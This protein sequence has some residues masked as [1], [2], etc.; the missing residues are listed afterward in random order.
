[1]DHSLGSK[2]I[3]RHRMNATFA[4]PGIVV[5]ICGIVLAPSCIG[6][7]PISRPQEAPWTEKP[8][9]EQLASTAI[10]AGEPEDVESSAAKPKVSQLSP[11]VPEGKTQRWAVLVHNARSFQPVLVDHN[12][13]KKERVIIVNNPTSEKVSEAF[14]E[15]PKLSR[16][17]LFFL[18]C[19]HHAAHGYLFNREWPWVCV[20][21]QL[22]RIGATNV[23][24]LEIC[25]GGLAI[26]RL[27]SAEMVYSACDSF[28][29]C[30][31]IF[32]T[33]FIAA[34]VSPASDAD[35][36]GHISMGEAYDKA[37][38]R[39]PLRKEYAKLNKRSPRFWPVPRGPSPVRS[40]GR[41]GHE[42]CVQPDWDLVLKEPK[43]AR[44]KN[45]EMVLSRWHDERDRSQVPP[46]APPR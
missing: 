44:G 9:T 46:V 24:V 45:R 7:K 3:K 18:A 13:W 6:C 15:V 31:G 5:L 43:Q 2:E 30:G 35:G 39:E 10:K 8:T 12:G 21:E 25:H 36:D 41:R 33:L 42:I 16:D 20:E 27:P 32:Q 4:V 14:A 40:A 34:M 28:S 11:T 19:C 1:M 37:A 23:V 22:K 38:R 29:K 17:D 26:E